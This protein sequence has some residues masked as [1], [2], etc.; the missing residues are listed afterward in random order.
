MRILSWVIGVPLAVIV[1]LFAL[2]NR[3]DVTVAFWPFEE[4]LALP[5]YLTVL[6][7][8]LVGFLLGALFASLRSVKYRRA[9]RLHAKRA[10]TLEQE[11]GRAVSSTQPAPAEPPPP[12][13]QTPPP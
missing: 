2:S 12:G 13:A 3:A 9:A 8:L 10:A 11:L 7:P 5:I 4:G 1:V 6:V